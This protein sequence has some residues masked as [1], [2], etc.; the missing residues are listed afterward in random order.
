MT[1]SVP[2][3]VIILGIPF[4]QGSDSQAADRALE[5]G[6]VLAPSAPGLAD[7]LNNPAYAQALRTAEMVIPDSGYMVLLWWLFR[8]VRIRRISGLALVRALLQEK[9]EMMSA[10]TLWVMPAER[11]A[12]ALKD[13]FSN[14]GIDLARESIYIAPFYSSP[15]L[16]DP[17]LL[18]RIQSERP[19]VIVLAIA[20]G[21]QEILGHWL[22][23]QLGYRPAIICIGAAI[24]FETGAQTAIPGW[25]DRL[26]LGWL[27]RL[28]SHPRLY[29]H[30]Y[31]KAIKLAKRMLRDR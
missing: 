15:E 21:K 19:A 22:R 13:Y 26:Y 6:L 1:T 17:V 12:V 28:L 30:R 29:T 2:D 31:L 24:A 27:L 3:P 5:G 10:S 8:G 11:D 7:D 4:F 16:G 25:A 9:S 14:R 23:E 18:E 20:G